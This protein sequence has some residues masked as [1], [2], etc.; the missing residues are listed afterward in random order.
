MQNLLNKI[1]VSYVDAAVAAANNTD[2][3]SSVVDTAGYE[4]VIFLVSILDSVA[5]GV[6][7]L[8]VS[9]GALSNGTD[10]AALAS[11][12]DALTSAVNDDINGQILKVDVYRPRE[13]Y[14]MSTITSATQNI[15]FGDTVAILYGPK[16]QPVSH[17]GTVLA[18][19]AEA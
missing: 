10:M 18:S 12:S 9:Q 2:S 3:D 19:P 7:T 15:A 13:R 1:A 5:G 8:T 11:G 17:T 14:V 4:G 6:A 16:D